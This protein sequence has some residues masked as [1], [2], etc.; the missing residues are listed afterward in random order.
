MFAAVSRTSF[1]VNTDYYMFPRHTCYD[2]HLEIYLQSEVILQTPLPCDDYVKIS[3]VPIHF[4]VGAYVGNTTRP[5]LGGT[6]SQVV[7]WIFLLEIWSDV[8]QTVV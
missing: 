8:F 1:Q 6:Y 5:C 2:E 4:Q 7:C 3:P